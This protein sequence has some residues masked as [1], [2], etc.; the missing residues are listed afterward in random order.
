MRKL[1]L[2]IDAAFY[3]FYMFIACLV[4]MF[5]EALLVRLIDITVEVSFVTVS[6]IRIVVY[7]LGVCAILAVAAYK[8]GFREA[9]A[10]PVGTVISG[11][12]GGVVYFLFC[13]LFS[14]EPFCAGGVKSATALVKFGSRATAK[15][16]SEKMNVL[17]CI[18]VFFVFLAVYIVLMAIF[19]YVGAK[20]RIAQR[21]ALSAEQ[22]SDEAQD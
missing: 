10:S 9:Y 18:P 6:V 15:L 13:M 5:A 1:D 8:E 2:L 19:K 12:F 22:E 20:N 17:D 21:E 4:T 3:A 16:V 14:F 11:F 7:A